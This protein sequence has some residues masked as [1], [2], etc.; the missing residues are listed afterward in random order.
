LFVDGEIIATEHLS[1]V[2]ANWL[3][4]STFKFDSKIKRFVL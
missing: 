4:G 2:M 1:L 3:S